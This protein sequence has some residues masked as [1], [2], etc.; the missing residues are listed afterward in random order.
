[1]KIFKLIRTSGTQGLENIENITW[2]ENTKPL[3]TSLTSALADFL[4]RFP[5]SRKEHPIL[6][7]CYMYQAKIDFI[8]SYSENKLENK[9][10]IAPCDQVDPFTISIALTPNIIGTRS[11]SLHNIVK[12]GES[13]LDNPLIFTQIFNEYISL[14]FPQYECEGTWIKD[15]ETFIIDLKDRGKE[16]ID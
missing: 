6:L 4:S 9:F 1:M 11:I 10:I 2:L 5:I 3:T 15:I 7:T 16:K 8:Y 14:L 12:Y 13:R